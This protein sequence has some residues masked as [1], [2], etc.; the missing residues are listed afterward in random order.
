VPE[1]QQTKLPDAGA[2]VTADDRKK[3]LRRAM[4]AGL[5]GSA[6]GVLGNPNTAKPTLG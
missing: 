1:R 6:Q 4:F 3:M 5:Q 2:P